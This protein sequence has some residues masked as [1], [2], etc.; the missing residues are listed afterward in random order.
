MLCSAYILNVIRNGYEIPF[1]SVPPKSSVKNNRS[2]LD[3]AD[4]VSE[5]IIELLKTNSIV[6]VSEQPHTVNPLTVAVNPKKLRLVLDLR[7]VNPYVYKEHYVFEDWKTAIQ[8]YSSN[9]Y[10]YNFDLKNGYHHIDINPEFQKYLGFAWEFNNKKRFFCFTVLPFGLS[11]AGLIFSKTLR[12]L[13][14]HWRASSIRIILYLDDGFGMEESFEKAL[15]NS[16][17]IRADLIAAGLIANDDK[18]NW[19]PVQILAW[20]G[21][22]ID[23]SSSTL[24]IPEKKI[25]NIIQGAQIIVGKR[26]CTARQLARVAG[27]INSTGIVVGDVSTLN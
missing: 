9:C 4:F 6:E 27:R 17:R 14:Q 13:V 7:N 11:T 5:A 21:I 2:A 24:T 18:S 26:V 20:L 3:H 1:V 25:D 15:V 8:F 19:E 12:C 16:K 22:N 23:S 10:M